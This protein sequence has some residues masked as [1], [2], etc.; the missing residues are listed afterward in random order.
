MPGWLEVLLRSFVGLVIILFGTKL[1][2]RKALGE[3]SYFEFISAIVVAIV[4]AVSSISLSIP[5]A[6]PMIS[7]FIW[8]LLPYF[9]RLLSMKSKTFRHLING[10]SVPIIKDGKILEDHLKKLQY[11]S[12]DLLSKL[13]AKNAFQVDD[14][15]F[16]VLEPN[17]TVNVMLKKDV[18]P[19]TPKDIDIQVANV[20]QPE[21]VIMD[22]KILDE[23][24]ANVGFNRL[25]L[26]TEL[27]K[28]GVALENVYLGQ[29]NSYGELTVDL[30]DDH[31]QVP[32]PTERP[33]LMATIKKVQADLESFAL[34]TNCQQAKNMYTNAAKDMENVMKR[35]KPFLH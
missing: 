21:T 31:I 27:E 16:A 22:G 8:L 7:L 11:S 13:R 30:Y 25:W 10:K 35:L 26:E 15:E 9:I 20:K 2:V 29:V 23:S 33:L 4:V 17:G 1:F 14:V 3:L 34:Q 28:L 12:D 32:S 6:Y 18:Q 5:L 24:L 19:L